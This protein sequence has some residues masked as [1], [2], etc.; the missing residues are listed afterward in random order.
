MF[1]AGS[2]L[3]AANPPDGDA[4]PRLISRT[5][6][7]GETW[8]DL[9]ELKAAVARGNP[10]AEAWYGELLLRGDGVP[11]NDREAVALLE[12]AARAGHSGA[13]FRL[14]MLLSHGQNG[15]ATDPARALAYFRA[16]AAGGE[17]EA[18]FNIGAAYASAR[19]VKRNYAEALAWLTV[20]R[21][22]GADGGAERNLREQLKS[23]PTWIATAERR[24]AEIAAEYTGRQVVDFLPPPAPL[25]A[26]VDP[27][28][29]APPS[30]RP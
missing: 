27:L 15:V 24:A 16:A 21:Q 2:G 20:A 7:G 11:R 12:K 19:G 1:G 26:P 10:R 6:G 23:R 14:G 29:P 13:A 9:A 30:S 18:F 8:A 17:A 28:R 5:G 22:R 25:D 4:A 3:R